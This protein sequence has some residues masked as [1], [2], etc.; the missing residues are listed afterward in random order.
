MSRF[1]DIAALQRASLG[2]CECPGTPHDEDFAMYRTQLG[3]SALARI[4]R[5]EIEGAVQHDPLAAHRQVILEAVTSWNLLWLDPSGDP[6][7]P[8]RKVVPVPINS[9]TVELLNDSIRPLAEEI[10]KAISGG[11]SPNASG[12]PSRASSRGSASR[13]R[14]KTAKRGT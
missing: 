6:D 8:D 5:A 11:P 9:G 13:A 7:D 12:A 3:A 14:T 10:D 1:A 4:G 2:P